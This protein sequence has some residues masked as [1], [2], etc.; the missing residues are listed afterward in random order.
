MNGMLQLKMKVGFGRER[1]L[2]V[3]AFQND[4]YPLQNDRSF[5]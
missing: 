1:K 3:G 5:S 2:H 4:D